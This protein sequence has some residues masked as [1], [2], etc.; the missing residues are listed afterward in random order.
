MA[1]PIP[2]I[3]VVSNVFVRQMEFASAGDI[4]QGHKHPHDHLT[5]LAKGALR[6]VVDGQASEFT[7]P[8]MILIRADK[9]H[10]LTALEDGT[11]AYCVHGLRGED[12]SDDLIDPEMVPRGPA[13]RQFLR[14]VTDSSS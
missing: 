1:Q 3:G 8:M 2:R 5:L 10:E 14:Q 11:V 12:K 7:A 4:E 13:L 9:E 6:I